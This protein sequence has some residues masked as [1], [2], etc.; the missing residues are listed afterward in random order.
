MLAIKLIYSM[1]LHY[2]HKN[3]VFLAGCHCD[4]RC[5]TMWFIFIGQC[6]RMR[7]PLYSHE[8]VC[9]FLT[10]YLKAKVTTTTRLFVHCI[11]SAKLTKRTPSDFLAILPTEILA[12]SKFILSSH[13]TYLVHFV[14]FQFVDFSLIPFVSINY[15]WEFP[16]LF[17][18]N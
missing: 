16:L 4:S 2:L 18:T 10:V 1:W 12:E 11:L 9:S 14:P 5:F 17:P 7:E 13:F 15:S 8:V 6:T 3:S